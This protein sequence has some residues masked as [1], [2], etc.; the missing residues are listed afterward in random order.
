MSDDI[1]ICDE[2][3]EFVAPDVA[4]IRGSL[5]HPEEVLC[6]NCAQETEI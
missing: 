4:T 6:P 2:C 1:L 3:H 5:T